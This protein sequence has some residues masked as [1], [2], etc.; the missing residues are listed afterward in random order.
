MTNKIYSFLGLATKAGRVATG[1]ETCERAI[2][3]GKALL[4]I[5]ADEAS[6]NTKKKFTDMCLYRNIQIRIFGDKDLLGRYTGKDLRSVVC[7]MDV[8]F[9]ENLV[10][11]IDAYKFEIGGGNIVESQDI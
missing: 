6:D 11:M 9:A 2:K 10:K 5:V 7:I 3:A 1:N 4:V 8:G